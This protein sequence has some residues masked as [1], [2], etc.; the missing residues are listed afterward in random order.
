MTKV[1]AP[2]KI[3][4]ITAVYNALVG[5]FLHAK[6]HGRIEHRP[7]VGA[8][9]VQVELLRIAGVIALVTDVSD[10]GLLMPVKKA[11]E[12]GDALDLDIPQG[13]YLDAHE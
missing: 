12:G 5:E 13:D 11:E 3:E 1:S 7:D 2:Q 6:D 9:P 10:L 4:A 8:I